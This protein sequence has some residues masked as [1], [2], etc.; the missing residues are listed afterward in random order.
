MEEQNLYLEYLENH[1]KWKTKEG[2]LD[3]EYD[4][5]QNITEYIAYF[6]VLKY[7]NTYI[8]ILESTRPNAATYIYS[9]PD[10][11]IQLRTFLYKT[12][13]TE[14]YIKRE[15]STEDK[16]EI[17]RIVA[18]LNDKDFIECSD[19]EEELD[20]ELTFILSYKPIKYRHYFIDEIE[21]GDITKW[22]AQL[23][24][25]INNYLKE[26]KQNKQKIEGL[27]ND[28]DDDVSKITSV[29]REY[30]YDG[31]IISSIVSEIIKPYEEKEN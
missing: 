16:E 20:N 4:S 23:E 30:M 28:D 26:G 8:G 19:E 9:F 29:M 7:E 10:T 21:H 13:L 5:N 11:Y 14:P 25:T 15:F 6:Y 12:H 3:R 1:P 17:K 31:G 2:W 27:Y 18:A 24:N 22:K